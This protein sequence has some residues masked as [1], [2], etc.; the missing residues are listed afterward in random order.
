MLFLAAAA[1]VGVAVAFAILVMPAFGGSAH[2]Y[3]DHAVP[4]AIS[5]HTS[6]VVASV[7]FDQRGFDTLGEETILLA[8]VMGV[9]ILLRPAEDETETQQ[10]STGRPLDSTRLGGYVFLPITLLIGFDLIS[11]GH[12]TPG[13]GFQGGVV[14]GT[15]MHLLYVAGRYSTLEQVRPVDL[16]D[17]GEA[18]GAGAFACLGIVA[19]V[20]SGAFLAN[21]LPHGTIG[22]L[23]SAGTVPVLNGA[24]GI[25]VASGTM[26]LLAKFLEQA[27]RVKQEQGSGGKK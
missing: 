2:P 10:L 26:V 5:E 14:L 27:I 11:Q 17:L 21:F 16:F 18:V 23:L 24:V 9:V 22:H 4:D 8:S 1:V 3:R 20:V 7:N 25:E 15:G 6:N 19:V 13:G 12:L